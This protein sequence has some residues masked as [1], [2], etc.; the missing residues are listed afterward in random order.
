[1]HTR[2]RL[3]SSQLNSH[4]YKLGFK[5][6]PTC[7]CGSRSE[8]VWHYFFVCPQY[9]VARSKLH[10]IISQYAPMSMKTILYG[11]SNCTLQENKQIFSAVHDFIAASSRFSQTGVGWSSGIY[12]HIFAFLILLLLF[13]DLNWLAATVVNTIT[14]LWLVKMKAPTICLCLCACSFSSMFAGLVDCNY[15]SDRQNTFSLYVLLSPVYM[16]SFSNERNLYR[17]CPFSNR[18]YYVLIA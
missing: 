3:G 16:L 12:M 4:L 18:I 17:A 1:M 9:T 15:F 14:Q 7:K 8:D 13:Y 2:L 6:H 5:L 10:T 11:D